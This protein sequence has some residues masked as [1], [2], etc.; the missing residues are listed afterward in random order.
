M[1]LITDALLIS[2]FWFVALY[3]LRLSNIQK[4]AIKNSEDSIWQK[5][6]MVS[7]GFIVTWIFVEVGLMADSASIIFLLLKD[8]INSPLLS[9]LIFVANMIVLFNAAIT[10]SSKA[11]ETERYIIKAE[12]KAITFANGL[13]VLGISLVIFYIQ[14]VYWGEFNYIYTKQ[15][16]INLGFEALIDG[17]FMLVPALMILINGVRYVRQEKIRKLAFRISI[18]IILLL[19]FSQ[20]IITKLIVLYDILKS[21]QKIILKKVGFD[22]KTLHEDPLLIASSLS[23]GK[24]NAKINAYYLCSYFFAVVVLWTSQVSPFPIPS[25]MYENGLEISFYIGLAI[26]VFWILENLAR[27]TG[28]YGRYFRWFFIPTMILLTI[29]PF[30]TSFADISTFVRSTETISLYHKMALSLG[31]N[32]YL[33]FICL[34]IMQASL[35]YILHVITG[36]AHNDRHH[37]SVM[38]IIFIVQVM[39]LSIM[40]PVFLSI[41][42]YSLSEGRPIIIPLIILIGGG[43]TFLMGSISYNLFSSKKSEWSSYVNDYWKN[44]KR[45]FTIIGLITLVSSVPVLLIAADPIHNMS[46]HYNWENTTVKSGE[47]YK[48][49]TLFKT[50][51]PKEVYVLETG[52]DNSKLLAVSS[53]DGH[54]IWEKTYQDFYVHYKVWSDDTVVLTKKENK[55]FSV[56]N[57][58]TGKKVYDYQIKANSKQEFLN[59]E[60]NDRAVLMTDNTTQTLYDM[61]YKEI[62]LETLGNNFYS[63][64]PGNQCAMLKNDKV[65]LYQNNRVE[66]I[67]GSYNFKLSEFIYYDEAGMIVFNQKDIVQYPFDLS[68]PDETTYL[69]LFEHNIIIN[70]SFYKKINN[71]VTFYLYDGSS[72]FAYLFN[73]KDFTYKVL[74]LEQR[75]K[76]LKDPQDIQI[77][78]DQGNYLLYDDYQVTLFNRENLIARQWYQLPEGQKNNKQKETIVAG[79][80]L[81]IDGKIIW[82]ETNGKIH[83]VTLK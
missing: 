78:D 80:P 34:S 67:V 12:K 26:F 10:M 66:K 53:E 25:N 51:V 63:L 47:K 42:S 5:A 4:M 48:V 73:T 49:S 18:P 11:L 82:I 13:I 7:K 21:V 30:Y 50:S 46:I 72:Q 45:L 43:I 8:V 64:I 31:N 1:K 60:V 17:L 65:Y 71:L 62:M 44:K 69:K 35:A 9:H 54:I 33:F 29:Y 19:G 74:T 75:I 36:E 56:I 37:Y 15:G 27:L 16:E 83:A 59:L 39:M 52:K 32:K 57:L 23:F 22:I 79:E 58:K 81:F 41:P 28:K 6:I 3:T 20:A 14:S 76:G 38:P 40:F 68:Q 70:E 55:G 77:C 2:S 61:E 24:T